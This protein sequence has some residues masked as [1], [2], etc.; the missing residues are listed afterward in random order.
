MEDIALKRG[1]GEYGC[2]HGAQCSAMRAVGSTVSLS[3]ACMGELAVRFVLSTTAV[4]PSHAAKSQF[5]TKAVHEFDDPRIA[6][7]LP[8]ATNARQP[9]EDA[10]TAPALSTITKS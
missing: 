10:M 4:G 9:F 2:S 5:T 8:S 7:W 3:S 1:S 6:P